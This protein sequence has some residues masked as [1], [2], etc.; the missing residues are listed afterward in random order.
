MKVS[1]REIL[2]LVLVTIPL[3]LLYYVWDS[4]PDT[5]PVHYGLNGKADRFDSKNLLLWM[6]PLVL[7]LSYIILALIPRI[8][9]KKRVDY[10]Q[11]GYYSIRLAVV[12]LLA[13]L[14]ASYILSIAGNWNFS[15]TVPLLIMGLLIVLGNYLPVLKPNYFIGIRTPWTLEDEKVWIKT[16][17]FCGRL[18]VVGGVIGFVVHLVWSSL[19]FSVSVGLVMLLLIASVAYSYYTYRGKNFEKKN[20]K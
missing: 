20:I 18:W 19:P 17:R 11:G 9:P 4:I 15:S 1:F 14:F 6:I 3:L 12:L 7:I 8:D 16:H 13:I 2:L 10:S 5:I